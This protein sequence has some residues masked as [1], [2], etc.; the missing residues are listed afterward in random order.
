MEDIMKITMKKAME[1]MTNIDDVS[2][3]EDMSNC[4]LTFQLGALYVTLSN[5]VNKLVNE[6]IDLDDALWQ[7]MMEVP[8][9]LI[10]A[11]NLAASWT[12]TIGDGDKCLG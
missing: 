9:W 10:G 7:T 11:Y 8:E 4:E 5:Q 1:V 3:T 6:D 2:T 12:E